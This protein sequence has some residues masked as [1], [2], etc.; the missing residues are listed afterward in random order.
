MVKRKTHDQFVG[1]IKIKHPYIKI[2]GRYITSKDRI[3]CECQK[4]GYQWTPTPYSLSAGHGCPKCSNNNK[5][6]HEELIA[7]LEN[8]N[9]NIEVLGKYVNS[10][11]KILCRCKIDGFE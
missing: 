3:L 6:T 1:E 2:L 4:D 9:P 5:R 7:E 8:I 10:T 11:T